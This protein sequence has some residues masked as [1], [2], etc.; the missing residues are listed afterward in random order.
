MD[1]E[2][3]DP[4]WCGSGKKYKRCHLDVDRDAR[5]ALAEAMPV[6]QENIQRGIDRQRRLRGEFALHIDFVSPILWQGQRVWAI[7]SRVY[8][9][10][11]ANETFHEFIFGVLAQTLG[12]AWRAGQAA[13]PTTGRHFV[14]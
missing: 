2:R 1:P 14:Y 13:L 11:Q 12:E 4:C 7:G 5:Q 6:I 3:N 8:T 9:G 10:R